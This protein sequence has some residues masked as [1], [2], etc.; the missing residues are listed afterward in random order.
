MLPAPQPASDRHTE[1]SPP[2]ACVTSLQ[3]Q[4]WC[5]PRPHRSD[6]HLL[7]GIRT[8]HTERAA[9]AKSKRRD[10]NLLSGSVQSEASPGFP[11]IIWYLTDP[12]FLVCVCV[13]AR[14]VCVC[15]R[16]CVCVGWSQPGILQIGKT[17]GTFSGRSAAV[18]YINLLL[19][20]QCSEASG[21]IFILIPS[22]R[23]IC[24]VCFL[25]FFI[26]VVWFCFFLPRTRAAA[27]TVCVSTHLNPPPPFFFFFFFFLEIKSRPCLT[28]LHQQLV[29]VH[30][31][32]DAVDTVRETH[33]AVWASGCTNRRETYMCGGG[34]GGEE[35]KTGLIASLRG[36]DINWL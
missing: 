13:R 19:A 35:E 33:T 4:P 25:L 16:M 36:C 21:D 7:H 2:A 11:L 32:W 6:P 27:Q 28:D 12:R 31:W 23:I 8:T 29:S 5:S 24:F 14:V 10:F 20:K 30:S 26:P 22:C 9:E 3:V 18:A 34:G 1:V 17:T 15:V